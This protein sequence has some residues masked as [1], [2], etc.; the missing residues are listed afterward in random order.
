MRV[1]VESVWRCDITSEMSGRIIGQ[2]QIIQ[3]R[4]KNVNKKGLYGAINFDSLYMR[5]R[6]SHGG[7]G[8]VIDSLPRFLPFAALGSE[9][10]TRLLYRLFHLRAVP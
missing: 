5:L 7:E 8:L 9:P 1:D 10:L 4:A 3:L 2:L 6:H